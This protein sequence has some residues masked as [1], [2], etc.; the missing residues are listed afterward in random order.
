MVEVGISN[1]ISLPNGA[2]DSDDF[3]INTEKY[4][5][6][7]NKF[8]ICTDNDEKGNFVSEK[9]AQ[10]LG[11]YRC[12]RV[13]FKN[14]DANADLIEGKNILLDSCKNSKKY[15]RAFPWLFL[16]L[17][18]PVAPPCLASTATREPGGCLRVDSMQRAEMSA[19]LP[20]P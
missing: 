20:S 1:V 15:P 18:R 5:Q 12:E 10:R 13:I 2:N 4:L 3:W 14:K 11:R 6:G 17:V 9:I 7:I 19:V 16:I 8:Y